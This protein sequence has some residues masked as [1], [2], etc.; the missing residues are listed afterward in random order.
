MKKI[1]NAVNEEQALSAFSDF[2]EKWGGKYPY[3]I[4]SWETNWEELMTF[5][6][7]PPEIRKLIF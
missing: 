3:A 2:S 4:K 1:Y 7:Y 6:K 5:M